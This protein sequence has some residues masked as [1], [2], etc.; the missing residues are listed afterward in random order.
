MKFFLDSEFIEDGSTIDL[1]SIGMVWDSPV[2]G[3]YYAI[4]TEFDGSKASDW[5]KHNVLAKLPSQVDR[6]ELFKSRA[7]IAQDIKNIVNSECSLAQSYEHNLMEQAPLSV[8]SKPEFYG[9]YADYDWVV[10]CQ[11]FG[12]MIDLPDGFP[13]YCRDIKQIADMLNVRLPQ[14]DSDEEHDALADAR[15]NMKSYKL[16]ALRI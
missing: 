4:S 8:P 16:L 9:Y 7:E 12:R 3:S 15:W 6:P 11:L 14:P 5:V 1:I 13:M 10:F 2:S